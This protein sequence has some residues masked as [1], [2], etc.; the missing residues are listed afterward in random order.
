M[1]REDVH[2]GVCVR[3][4]SDYLRIP[5]GTLATVDTVGVTSRGAH[6][7]FTVHWLNPPKGTR[8]RLPQIAA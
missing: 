2:Q 4:L 6:F 8:S 5:A 1:R 3:L 7:S